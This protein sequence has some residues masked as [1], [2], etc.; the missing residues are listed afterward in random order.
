M[1]NLVQIQAVVQLKLLKHR[2]LMYYINTPSFEDTWEQATV[3]QQKKFENL[4]AIEDLDN[5][6]LEAK[7]THSKN[8]QDKTLKELREIAS[9]LLIPNYNK[10]H[11]EMLILILKD[12]V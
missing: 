3:E 10:Y 7:K 4:I 9:R 5:L 8:L 2:N 11:K 1:S 12:K 6:K